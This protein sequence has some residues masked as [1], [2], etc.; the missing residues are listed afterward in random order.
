MK[1][2]RPFIELKTFICMCMSRQTIKII[3]LKFIT[4]GVAKLLKVVTK[5]LMAAMA[6]L[7]EMQLL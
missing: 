1:S 6:Y 3:V 4:K 2:Q 5:A 7:E